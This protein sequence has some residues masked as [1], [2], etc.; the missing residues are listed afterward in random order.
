MTDE[1]LEGVRLISKGIDKLQAGPLDYYLKKLIAARELLL[2]RFAPFRVGDTV[3]I[4]QVPD[5]NKSPGWN[6]CRHFLVPGSRA[7]IRSS[8][9]DDR[10]CLRFEVEF[11][12]ESWID[13]EGTIRPVSSKHIFCFFEDELILVNLPNGQE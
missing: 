7:V 11:E 13:S 5:F 9:C 10:G 1:L 6:G 4:R 2:T 3:T 8:D 12:T